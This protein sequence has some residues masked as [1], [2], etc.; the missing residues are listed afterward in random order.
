MASFTVRMVL[1]DADWEDYNKLYEEMNKEGFSDE[2]S[3]NDGTAYELPD[4]E[5]TI[6]GNLTK[7]DVLSK[8]KNA[9]SKTG[10]KYAVLVT[11]S[12]G[13]TWYGLKKV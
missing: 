5:Y 7:S 11:Q 10:K 6:S 3:S 4:G 13:R 9:A 8:A 2:I 1:H 12:S